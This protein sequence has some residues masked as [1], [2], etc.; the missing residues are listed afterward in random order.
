MKISSDKDRVYYIANKI[1]LNI[2][3]KNESL[4]MKI[5][6]NVLFFNKN[7][8]T[9]F[10]TTLG[11]NVYFP[12]S[13]FLNTN[14]YETLPVIFHEKCHDLDSRKN[15]LFSFL[16]LFPQILSPFAL[17][18]CL[19]SFWLSI[20]I[21]VLFLLPLPA[22]WRHK[23]E[24]RG[25]KMSLFVGSEL[26]KENNL[27]T[28]DTLI[29]LNNMR[30]SIDRMFRGSSYYFMW[31]FGVKKELDETVNKIL[32]DDIVKDDPLYAQVRD[33]LI[34]TRIHN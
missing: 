31:P 1:N 2:K 11:N 9:S 10:I 17:L 27:S 24:L 7:F 28:A 14:T 18:L 19:V 22:Y 20:A 8:M 23:Y 21:S 32:S 30:N 6:G 5:L 29:Y 3:F 16:Y 26:C 15:K 12:S 34:S 33:L 13:D 25:Y 4:A